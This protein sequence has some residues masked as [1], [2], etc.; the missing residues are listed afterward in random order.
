MKLM[1][2]TETLRVFQMHG[3]NERNIVD[4]RLSSEEAYDVVDVGAVGVITI[5][6]RL[7]RARREI[8]VTLKVRVEVA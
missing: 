2:D 3:P 8:R 7:A 5:D 6:T 4:A 1:F